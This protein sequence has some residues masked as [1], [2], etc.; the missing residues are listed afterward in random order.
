MPGC[1]AVLQR[2]AWRWWFSLPGLL[3]F[4]SPLR[5]MCFPALSTNRLR[6]LFEIQN[7]HGVVLA[8][9]NLAKIFLTLQV[10]VRFFTPPGAL[11]AKQHIKQKRIPFSL[12][13]HPPGSSG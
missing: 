5:R 1:S 12:L 4:P 3:G 2:C 6:K 7:E 9:P 13:P 11:A 8:E 10:W